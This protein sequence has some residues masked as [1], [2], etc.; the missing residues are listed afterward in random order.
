MSSRNTA[1]SRGTDRLAENTLAQS[2]LDSALQHEVDLAAKQLLKKLL[3]IHVAIER[4]LRKLHQKVDVTLRPGVS[5]CMRSEERE[6][7]DP[8]RRQMR[9]VCVDR[10]K[11]LVACHTWFTASRNRYSALTAVAAAARD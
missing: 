9:A 6:L 7:N 1:A 10:P 8:E 11:D 5:T 2:W 4:F 3:Q